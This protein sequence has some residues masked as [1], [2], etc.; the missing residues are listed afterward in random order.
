[1]GEA[2]VNATV[3][4][5]VEETTATTRAARAIAMAAF[6]LVLAGYSKLVGLPADLIQVLAWMWLGTIAWNIQAPRSTHLVFLRDWWPALAVL[7]IYVYS[8]GMTSHLG[9]SVHITEPILLDN[10]LGGGELPTQQLQKMLCGTPCTSSLP[11]R[12]YDGAL[13]CVY[14]THFI[15]APLVALTLYL[16][17]RLGWVSFMR[18]YVSLY[19]AGLFF[20]ITYPMAPPWLASRDGYLS[21]E[22][23]SRITGRGWS[24]IGLEHFQ[25]W[26]SRLGNQVAA[27]PSLHAATAALIAFYGI[28]HLRSRWRYVLLLYP[29]AMGF[30]L[31]Y[32]AEHYVVD[33][34]AGW[35]LAVVVIWACSNWERGGVLRRGLVA[36]NDT[37]LG[38][39]VGQPPVAAN[40]TILG[41]R[42][43]QPLVAEG[44]QTNV[45]RRKEPFC[46][47][48]SDQPAPQKGTFLRRGGGGAGSPVGWPHRL[49]PLVLPCLLLAMLIVGILAPAYSALPALLIAGGLVAWL[50]PTLRLG[51]GEGGRLFPSFALGVVALLTAVQ[52]V[53]LF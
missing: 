31:V 22:P 17:D 51:A 38:R 45:L 41:G 25:Q 16:R 34:L 46:G 4:R 49:P 47:R 19:I 32:Y 12:W 18:R 20:Y 6:V 29:T 13:T 39:R 43:G 40:D 24:V 42:V 27:M 1:M 44:S 36:A 7:E 14:Y 33:I 15:A 9:L 35:V 53:R 11:A 3:D 48:G 23:V 26:L 52:M 2:V 30:M 28:A 21:G 37:I 50:T 8:R 5:A 10:W